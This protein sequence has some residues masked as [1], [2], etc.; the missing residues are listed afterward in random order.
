MTNIAVVGAT[1]LVGNTMLEIL[2]LKNIPYSSLTLFSSARSAGKEVTLKGKTYVVE[3]LTEEKTDG[4]FDYVLMSA[5][6]ETSLHFAPL[7]E[8]AG[9]V[10]IDNS[11]AWRM[12]QAIDLVVPEVN[13]PSLKRH[14]IANPNCSTIQSVVPLKP[15]AD[16][17]GVR[18]V[19]YTTYQSVSGSGWKGIEDLE[20]GERGEAAVNYPKPIYHNVIPQI[21]VFL[22]N[23]YTKEEEKMIRET[24]KIL[25]DASIDVTATCVRVPVPHAHAVAINVTLK[26][27]PSVEDLRTA[28]AGFPSI[29]LMDDPAQNLYPTPLDAAGQEGVFVGRIRKDNSLKNTYHLWSVSDNILKG[30]ALNAVQ[31]LEELLSRKEDQ[32]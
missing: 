16:A 4:G 26:A 29:V 13:K 8:Q 25:N 6:G 15:L 2:D 22:D 19:A 9:A 20:R 32:Q 23:G 12:D 27:E 1:G 30:A 17:F 28:L 10:V 24:Q 3:E 14:I 5:G 7:F 11:S 18:R 21:D 31:I